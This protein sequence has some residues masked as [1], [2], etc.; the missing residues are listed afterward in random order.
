MLDI[1]L[2]L[3]HPDNLPEDALEWPK[4]LETTTIDLETTNYQKK[5]LKFTEGIPVTLKTIFKTCDA[6]MHTVITDALLGTTV[7]SIADVDTHPDS[8]MLASWAGKTTTEEN[9][10]FPGAET[11]V[12]L[13]PQSDYGVNERAYYRDDGK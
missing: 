4:W 8:A 6:N 12:K 3:V 5:W 1:D 11:A 2:S 13:L 7:M 9:F 10:L